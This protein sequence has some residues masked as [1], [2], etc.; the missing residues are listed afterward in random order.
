[1]K[2]T[3]ITLI[4]QAVLFTK[5]QSTIDIAQAPLAMDLTAELEDRILKQ[6]KRELDGSE[7]SVVFT[8]RK[9]NFLLFFQ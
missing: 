3:L 8:S 7:F 4:I 2:S 1:M 6:T 9:N 5:I